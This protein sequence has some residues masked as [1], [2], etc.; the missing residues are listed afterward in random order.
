MAYDVESVTISLAAPIAS[1]ATADIHDWR[2]GQVLKLYRDG[3]PRRVG[4]REARITSALHAAGARVP[5]VG[6]LIE[7]NRRIGLP[8]EKLIGQPLS[9]RLIDTES[10]ASAGRVAAQ[11]HAAMHALTEPSLPP[12][13]EQ[14]GKIVEAGPLTSELKVRVLT[15]M[16][17]LPDGDR[18]CHGD[19]HAANIIVTRDGPVAIDCVV[20]HRGN[21]C[22]DVAQTCVAM[23]EWLYGELSERSQRAVESFL[24]AY[25]ASY[26]ELCPSATDEVAAWRPIVAAVRYSLPH[27]RTSSDLLLRMA[28]SCA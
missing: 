27:A 8:M 7:V 28:G 24:A 13:R 14:F 19:F 1:G 10:G 2:D 22:A 12:M 11:L 15:A 17:A 20:A 21:P 18:I 5:A 23:T 9:S 6:E 26:F 25:E 16:R 4:T 3:I